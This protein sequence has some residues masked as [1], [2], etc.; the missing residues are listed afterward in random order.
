[1]YVLI[2]A[3][4]F[5]KFAFWPLNNIIDLFKCHKKFYWFKIWNKF[6]KLN[7]KKFNNNKLKPKQHPKLNRYQNSKYKVKRKRFFQWARYK[8]KTK[9]RTMILHRRT[10]KGTRWG[11][12]S[13]EEAEEEADA[14]TCTREV[15]EDGSEASIWKNMWD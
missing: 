14:L 10:S 5:N 6:K 11:E 8:I 2:L 13:E 15:D 9:L 12:E 3:I 7:K 4:C 1:M